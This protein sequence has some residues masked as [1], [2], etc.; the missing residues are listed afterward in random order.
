MTT[1]TLTN[2]LDA[3]HKVTSVHVKK[4][5]RGGPDAAHT[6]VQVQLMRKLESAADTA[7][8]VYGDVVTTQDMEY[9][10]NDLPKYT[11]KAN[12]YESYVYK[13]KE[14][15]V[16]G[17][18]SVTKENKENDWTITNTRT[19]KVTEFTG[20][21]IWKDAEKETSRPEKITVELY[22]K[23][24][25]E[26]LNKVDETT[27]DAN[28]NFTFDNSGNGYPQYDE[29]GNL[30]IY[31]V[32][33]AGEQ[34]SFITYNGNKYNVTYG[35]DQDGYTIKNTL[36]DEEKPIKVTKEWIDDNNSQ[37]K[38]PDS[39][40]VTLVRGNEAQE[41][42]I[43]TRDNAG[44]DSNSWSGEFTKKYPMYDENGALYEYSVTENSIEDY[45]LQSIEG[46][47][48]D[49]FVLKNV[50]KPNKMSVTV[51][52]VWMD[53]N[54]ESNTR[55]ESLTLTL[56][57]SDGHTQE[58]QVK[59]PGWSETVEVEATDE[60]GKLYSYSVK[61]PEGALEEKKAIR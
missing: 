14:I 51:S 30:Y 11:D 49:G 58:V 6:E 9:T 56:V 45:T 47:A 50:Y 16:D 13:V 15:S 31:S 23:S 33:E 34:N 5:W 21:K 29:S 25:K 57:R 40:K 4:V 43:L 26:A 19:G 59:A 20:K 41:E 54:N 44:E 37:N 12:G 2:K 10:W 3:D 32:K 60:N 61:E 24:E 39:V 35:E 36:Y 52:K 42:I 28:W 27:T 38:R 22:R 7:W 46:N 48:T 1:F 53:N 17:Y 18:T 55:P 8:E